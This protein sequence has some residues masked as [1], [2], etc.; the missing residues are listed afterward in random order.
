MIKS[1]IYNGVNILLFMQC[2]VGC[3]TLLPKDKTITVGTWDT[4]EEAQQTFDK[5]IPLKTTLDD[6]KKLKIDPES[7]ANINILN[8]TD[9]TNRFI[10]GLSIESYELDTGI[11]ECILAKTNCKGYEINER[12]VKR[13]RYGNFWADLFNFK[14]KTDIVGWSFNGIVLIN[15]GLVV[16]KL[17]SGKPSIHEKVEKNNPLGPLQSGG[18]VTDILKKEL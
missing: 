7:N 10:S 18:I 2:L 5:I 15:D 4:F 13:K 16:Y 8:Y 14:R 9:V 11:E 6:L 3:S 17:S 1:R 12:V